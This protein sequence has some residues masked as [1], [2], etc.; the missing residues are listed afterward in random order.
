MNI[1]GIDRVSGDMVKIA[2]TN[3]MH[4]GLDGTNS[5]EKKPGAASFEQAMIQ[6]MEGVNAKQMS[7]TEITQRMLTDPD[8][9]DPHDVTI[10]QAQANL[11]LNIARTVIDRVVRGWKE[12]TAGR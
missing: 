2:R 4:L 7:S 9:V 12:V 1:I 5:V 3:P 10:A 6:A 11:S 8:S